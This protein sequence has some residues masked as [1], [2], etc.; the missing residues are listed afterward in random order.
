MG[1]GDWGLGTGVSLR[2]HRVIAHTPS[3]L[4]TTPLPTPYSPLP[5][6][7][8]FLNTKHYKLWYNEI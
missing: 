4:T 3:Q 7:H 8:Y 1:I 5:S 2:K 6:P